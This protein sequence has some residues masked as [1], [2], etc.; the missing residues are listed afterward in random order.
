MVWPAG[1]CAITLCLA[2]MSRAQDDPLIAPSP[3]ER[4]NAAPAVSQ[5]NVSP[6][7]AAQPDKGDERIMGV[8]PNFLTVN[9]PNAPFIPLTPKQ[10]WDLFVR[11]SVD[12]YTAFSAFLSAAFSQ[13][14]NNDP[15]YGVGTKA[16]AAR[17]GAALGDFTSQ[18]FYS[19]YAL[20]VLMHEDPRYYRRGPQSRILVRVGYSVAQAV[21]TRTDKGTRT[22]NFAVVLGTGMGIVTSELYYPEASRNGSVIWSR[23]GTSMMGTAIG[24]LMSEFWPD[25]RTRVLPHVPLLRRF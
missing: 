11:S 15:K 23:V 25:L 24:N 16:Y 20:A 3:P 2:P 7:K 10:K 21:S 1:L 17:V 8:I 14:G 18:N 4:E 19:G 9:D 13:G 22:F 6:L 5:S 12:P